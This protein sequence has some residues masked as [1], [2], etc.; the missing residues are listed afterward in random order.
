MHSPYL[1]PG[2]FFALRISAR[3]TPRAFEKKCEPLILWAQYLPCTLMLVIHSS[4]SELFGGRVVG[5]ARRN[6]SAEG[7][8]VRLALKISRYL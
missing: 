4:A 8:S 2:L 3:S 7:L 5:P 1:Q 6:S